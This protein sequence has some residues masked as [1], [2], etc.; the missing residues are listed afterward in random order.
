MHGTERNINFRNR[1]LVAIYV[2][3][4][5]REKMEFCKNVKFYS[6]VLA[7][8]YGSCFNATLSHYTL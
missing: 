3:S 1:K 7:F 8:H 2:R 4:I 6:V 5:L